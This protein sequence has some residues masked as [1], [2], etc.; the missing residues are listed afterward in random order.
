MIILKIATMPK[1][2]SEKRWQ[3]EHKDK[4]KT[5]QQNY[6][7]DKIHAGVV[8]DSWVVAEIDTFKPPNQTYGGWVR[9]LVEDWAK[10][11]ISGRG[12]NSSASPPH[13]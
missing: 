6:L 5:Y 8:L 10:S 13:K 12:M 9:Q 1:H 7:K 11:Q 2:E 3:K 4:I